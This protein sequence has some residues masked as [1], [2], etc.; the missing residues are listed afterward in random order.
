MSIYEFSSPQHKKTTFTL[1]IKKYDSFFSNVYKV[2]GK[3]QNT[4]L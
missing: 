2:L 1:N 4:Q 3:R